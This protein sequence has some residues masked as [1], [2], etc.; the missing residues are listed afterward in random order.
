MFLAI[1]RYC[2]GYLLIELTGESPERFLNMCIHHNI[3]IWNLSYNGESYTCCI[4]RIGFKKLRPI[5][6]KTRCKIRINNKVG[7][8]FLL[9][10]YRNRKI[11]AAGVGIFLFT[12]FYLSR[13]VWSIE[14]YGNQ[15]YTS[16]DIMEY[17]NH[18]GIERGAK[19]KDIICEDI[20]S[21]LRREYDNIIW[22]S[23]HIEG[24][25]LVVHIRENQTKMQTKTEATPSLNDEPKDS[26]SNSCGY[27]IVAADDGIITEM[28]TSSGTPLVTVGDEV[29]KGQVLV[30]GRIDLMSDYQEIVGYNYVS[31]EAK[32][33]L[34]SICEYFDEEEMQYQKKVYGDDIRK[35]YY[36]SCNDYQWYI[37]DYISHI[38]RK[39]DF[40]TN[41]EKVTYL[42]D[43][44]PAQQSALK[45][46]VGSIHYKPYDWIAAKYS[47]EEMRIR[48]SEKYNVY[49][50]NLNEKDVEII[51]NNVKIHIGENSAQALGTLVVEY[52]NMNFVKTEIME[53]PKILTEEGTTE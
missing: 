4:T 39:D 10:R 43:I 27:D 26:H 31:A 50:D 34:K 35:E 13:F 21:L 51:E 7:V 36:I 49:C 17:F 1:C 20:V 47:K 28:V 32:I 23:A 18:Q 44:S 9:F 42:N 48:L 40:Q 22:A 30:S 12:I 38:L 11:F 53:P 33:T 6:A 25:T 2:I 37:E 45:V 5:L 3:N 41:Y 52:H 8:P 19:T 29:E 14:L 16:E 15:Q 24:S 46:V